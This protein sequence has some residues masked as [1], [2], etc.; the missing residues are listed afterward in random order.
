MARRGANR[1]GLYVFLAVAALAA[2]GG[3]LWLAGE[4]A[5]ARREAQ[6]AA[7]DVPVL[8][9]GQLQVVGSSTSETRLVALDGLRR[10]PDGVTLTVL[11]IGRSAG[12]LEGKVAMIATRETVDCAGRRVFEGRIGAF[13]ADGRLVSATNGYSAKQ[14]RPAEA[15]DG[16]LALACGSAA[17]GRVFAGLN[18]AQR[19][20]QAMPDG[21]DQRADAAPD[22]PRLWAWLCATEARGHWRK[23]APQDCERAIRLN[24]GD[25]SVVAERGFIALQAGRNAAAEADF[26]KALALDPQDEAARLGHAAILLLRGDRAGSR[27]L[28]GEVLAVDPEALMWLQHDYRVSIEGPSAG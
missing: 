13:D 7:R 10:S 19:A 2:V 23:Q 15:A 18:A 11:R 21:Y 8:P 16:E 12:A 9:A 28:A 4:Q 3:G 25:A 1:T 17:K 14:G 22:D 24:P 5:R 27:K 26:S 6:A 20:L